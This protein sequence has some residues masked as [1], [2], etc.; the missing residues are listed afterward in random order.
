MYSDCSIS[1]ASTRTFMPRFMLGVNSLPSN[2]RSG[3]TK[4]RRSGDT[5]AVPVPSATLVTIFMPI[6]TPARR[7][8]W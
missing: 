5:L 1:S 8:I 3:V 2:S 7:D 6:H 4:F